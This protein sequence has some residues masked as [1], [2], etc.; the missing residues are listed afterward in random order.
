MP[1]INKWYSDGQRTGR[2]TGF[3]AWYAQFRRGR[4]PIRRERH[5]KSQAFSF[6]RKKFK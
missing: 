1:D 2:K 5:K 4:P 6:F 3:N